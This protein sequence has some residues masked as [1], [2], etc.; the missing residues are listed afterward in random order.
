MILVVG[1]TGALGGEICRQLVA[2]EMR[3]RA[4]VRP[5]SDPVKTAALRAMGCTLVQGDL[6]DRPSLDRA[7]K[8]ARTVITT[9]STTGSRQTGDSIQNV[10][11][12][13]QLALVAAARAAGV[14]HFIYTSFSQD[15][16]I[17]CPLM[18][19]KRAVEAAVKASGMAYTILRPSCFMESWLSPALGVD[20][21]NGAA[22]L[23]GAGDRPVSYISL[24]DVAAFAVACVN[25][26]AARN[27]EIELGGPEAISPLDV[28]KT[29][30]VIAGRPFTV[31]HVPQEAL[32]AQYAGASDPLGKS[33]A[34]L[35]LCIARGNP[36]PMDATL[37]QYPIHLTSVRE[38]AQ[39]TLAAGRR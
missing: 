32:E 36:I 19:A 1:A 9:V 10:D 31:Q 17:P 13:G 12:D 29:A 30:E 20:I 33:F 16:D 15:L 35:M 8:G 25:S 23:L 4:M 14:S 34:A 7:V 24:A 6:K 37:R 18:T 21:V 27:A 22:Q 26:P 38:F 2:G 3:V 28:V 11:Q 39:R 5:T